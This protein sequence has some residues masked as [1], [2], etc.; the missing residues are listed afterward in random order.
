M[1]T[2][3][4]STKSLDASQQFRQQKVKELVAYIRGKKKGEVV[5]IGRAAFCTVLNLISTTFLSMDMIDFKSESAQ[6][7]KDLMWGLMEETGRPNI[8][9]FFPLLA[10]L[11]LQGRRRRVAAYYKKLNDFFHQ[12]IEHRLAAA[13]VDGG[14][15][16]DDV[17]D[18]LLQSSREIDSIKL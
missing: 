6:E 10:P 14:R 5:C 2:H 8:S 16:N 18:A 9:D 1:K 7:L 11:D 4:F 12:M 13:T 17:L 3:L 15:T